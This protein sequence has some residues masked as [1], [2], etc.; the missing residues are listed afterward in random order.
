MAAPSTSSD[1][2]VATYQSEAWKLF[3]N[4]TK[5]QRLQKA[6]RDLAIA[7][8]GCAVHQG[9][10]GHAGDIGKKLRSKYNEN[11]SA[12]I[13]EIKRNPLLPEWMHDIRIFTCT[14]V[15]Y[16]RPL[17]DNTTVN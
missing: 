17:A 8:A 11:A 4:T 14:D 2:A 5:T 15:G 12:L 6:L 13:A 16:K 3:I 1:H 9:V 7:M 10:K